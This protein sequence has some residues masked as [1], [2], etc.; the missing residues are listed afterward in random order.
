MRKCAGVIAAAALVFG[1]SLAM[2][3]QQPQDD[4]PKYVNGNNLV[5]PASYRE[6]IFLSSGLD[7]NYNPPPGAASRNPPRHTFTNVYVNPSSY[8]GFMQTGKWP[9]GSV[10]VL[11]ARAADNVSKF[12]PANQIGLF[13][14]TFGAIE[15]NVKDS[16]FADGWAF[17]AFNGNAESAEPLAGEAL[18]RGQCVECHTKETAVERTFVQFYPTLLEVARQKGTLKPGF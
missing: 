11:E 2:R 15:A 10:F 18:A 7:L 9:N 13:Q 12:F 14:T 16:R 5:R 6:W 1:L 3:A 8:R 17:F 4:G